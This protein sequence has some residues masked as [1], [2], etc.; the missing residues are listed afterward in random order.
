MGFRLGLVADDFV[1]GSLL[2]FM[3]F[4]LDGGGVST[5][6]GG[7]VALKKFGPGNATLQ[8][9]RLYLQ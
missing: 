3:A 4:V 5:G 2:G 8:N 9:E 1:E 7:E 6:T